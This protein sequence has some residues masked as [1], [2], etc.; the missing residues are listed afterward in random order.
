MNIW[1]TCAIPF[2]FLLDLLLADPPALPH[3]VVLM[4]K[5]ISMME[6]LLRK[7]FPPDPKGESAGGWIL[8]VFLP[9]ATFLLT[10]GIC[11]LCYAIHPAVFFAVQ[12]FWGYQALAAR[13]LEI[14]AEDV[15]RVLLWGDLPTARKK[16]SRIVGRDTDVLDEAGVTRACVET[17]AENSSD[18]V[19]APLFYM[20]IGGAPLALTY[21][22]INT[23][24]SMVGYRNKRYIHFGRAA[25]VLDDVVNFIPS[26][27]A[28][29]FWILA[30]FPDPDADGRNAWRIFRRDRKKHASPNS[31]QTESACAGALHV[32]LGGPAS[33]FGKWVKKP[34][35]GDDDRPIEPEDI[36]RS[37]RLMWISCAF[38]LAAGLL[39][40]G[41]IMALIG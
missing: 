23:M 3:P 24:D 6:K 4:G 11:R 1:I 40:R 25:A 20:L 22:A 41:V 13:G 32:I 18:G 12:V 29:L 5:C 10:F 26:R 15:R 30:S 17:V 39:A 7:I 38:F 36:H 35:I 33:Y 21:K 27:I 37:V 2:A 8:A 19:V 28:G 9:L 31:A 14:E 34:Y 16:V